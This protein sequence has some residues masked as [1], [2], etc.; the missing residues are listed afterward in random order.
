MVGRADQAQRAVRARR[1][2]Q[3]LTAGLDEVRGRTG[4]IGG[5]VGHAVPGD[6]TRRGQQ[7]TVVAPAPA[8]EVALA[9]RRDGRGAVVVQLPAEADGTLPVGVRRTV[10]R[11]AHVDGGDPFHALHPFAFAVIRTV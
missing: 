1:E 11:V 3:G 8:V 9:G 2:Q 7:I 5:V 10:G 6:R 4:R